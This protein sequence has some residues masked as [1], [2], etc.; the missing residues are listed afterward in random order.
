MLVPGDVLRPGPSG[1]VPQGPGQSGRAVAFLSAFIWPP[2]HLRESP[3]SSFLSTWGLGVWKP[4][5][6]LWWERVAGRH[7]RGRR[8]AAAALTWAPGILAP[9]E[10]SRAPGMLVSRQA[11]GPE[12]R[13]RGVEEGCLPRPSEN[14]PPH[15]ALSAPRGPHLPRS[16]RAKPSPC[17]LSATRSLT[18]WFHRVGRRPGPPAS[19]AI[20]A[21]SPGVRPLSCGHRGTVRAPQHGLGSGLHA[22]RPLAAPCLGFPVCSSTGLPRH[23]G[24]AGHQ[25]RGLSTGPLATAPHPRTRVG[26][27]ARGLGPCR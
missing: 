27:P 18:T 7:W 4:P 3:P 20:R 16:S 24:Q 17:F 2:G 10:C 9:E 15:L 11:L 14:S 19:F 22:C 1:S 6:S 23:A 8:V 26:G 12:P 13:S 25:R 21:R 5:G